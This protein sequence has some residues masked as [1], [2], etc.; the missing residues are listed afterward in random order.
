MTIGDRYSHNIT[1]GYYG[2]TRN[3]QLGRSPYTSANGNPG[4]TPD[5]YQQ[6]MTMCPCPTSESRAGIHKRNWCPLYGIT[7]P[8][9]N[10]VSITEKIQAERREAR[11]RKRVEAAYTR[12][13]EFT[14]P[15]LN[16]GED[17]LAVWTYV[18]KSEDTP[19]TRAVVLEG[20]E[21]SVSGYNGVLKTEDFLGRM[22]QLKVSA[23]D[24]ELMT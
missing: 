9:E 15:W 21:W 10:N 8:K 7:P 22:I 20:D 4:S 6:M 11:E 12:W 18:D 16:L 2:L 19:H 17:A 13:D 23:D 3:Q 1:Q 5:S 24:L 14:A